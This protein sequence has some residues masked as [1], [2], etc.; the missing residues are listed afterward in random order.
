MHFIKQNLQEETALKRYNTLLCQRHYWPFINKITSPIIKLTFCL[1][2]ILLGCFT[3]HV[4][5]NPIQNQA[6]DD[7]FNQ[8]NNDELTGTLFTDEKLLELEALI[9]PNDLPRLQALKTFTCKQVRAHETDKLHALIKSTDS[10]SNGHYYAKSTPILLN[11]CRSKALRYLGKHEQAKAINLAML[12]SATELNDENVLASVHNSIGQQALFENQFFNAI[13]SIS[14]SYELHQKIGH[15]NSAN[16]NII[17]LASAYRRLGD[18]DKALYYYGIAEQRLIENQSHILLAIVQHSLAYIK[19]DNGE[20]QTALAYFQDVLNVANKSNNQLYQTRIKVDMAAPLIKLSRLEEADRILTDA[21]TIIDEEMFS[22]YGYMHAYLFELRF[23][24]SLNEQALRHFIEAERSFKKYNNKKGLSLIY[25]LI[26]EY[27]AQQQDYKTAN[28][29]HHQFLTIHLELDKATQETYN[30]EMRIRFDSKQLEDQQDQL[31]Q[32]QAL[33]EQQ[34]EALKTKQRLQYIALMLTAVFFIILVT[35]LIKLIKK[36]IQYK[37]LSLT[38]PLTELPNRLFAYQVLNKL[39]AQKNQFSILLL[40]VDHFKSVNDQYGHDVGDRALQLIAKQCLS[41]LNKDYTLSRIGG[42]EFLII[43][44]ST[45]K[46]Q[47]IRFAA[48]INQK[49]K[50]IDTTSLAMNKPF[51]A[52]IGISSVTSSTTI[53]TQL[54]QADIALYKAKNNGRDNTVHF[55]DCSSHEREEQQ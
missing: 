2:L 37:S 25:Q 48:N 22:H 40:D 34:L 50:L 7:I 28:H 19:L 29:W 14:K 38:D 20:Y 49:I 15:T 43:M 23:L 45:D 36:S 39:L 12:A 4:F 33:K 41:I 10:I 30:S 8:F 32:F 11:L 24:Q 52:S 13:E 18:N 53:S 5:A 42:E 35:F 47:A 9:A 26:S 17:E 6:A 44:P 27:F 21:Q 51:T 3:Q 16:L 1:C 31:L 46:A 55:Q 54:K